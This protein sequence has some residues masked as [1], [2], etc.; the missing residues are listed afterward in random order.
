MLDSLTDLFNSDNFMPHGHC[1]LWEPQILWLHVVSDA[2]IGAAYFSIPLALL[3]F[4]RKRKD[5]PFHHLFILFGLFI[6]LCGTTHLFSIWVLWKPDY[7]PEG[8][9]KALTAL[10]S[11]VTAVITWRIIP[12]ALTLPSP[13]QLEEM[14]FRLKE[15]NL[16]IEQEV[17]MRTAELKQ[18]NTKLQISENKLRHIARQSE[19][20]FRT[21]VDGVTDYALYM[22]DTNGIIIN[23]NAGAQRIKGYE[24]AEIIGQHFSRFYK[25]ED[26]NAGQPAR[27]L[28]TAITEGKYEA[29][30]WR[31]RKDGSSFRAHV[32]IDP[33]YD[34]SHNLVGFAKLTRDITEQHAARTT[35][36]KTR[37]QLYQAQKME[38]IGH[39]T[40]GIAHDFN[41]LLQTVMGG[42][43]LI[44]RSIV[45]EKLRLLI[46]T[47]QKAAARGARLT[48][49]LLAYSRQQ[50]LRPETSDINQ[51]LRSFEI[52]LRQA[53]GFGVQIK[54]D[55]GPNLWLTDIDQ[56]QFQS[57]I[58]NLV[59]NARDAMPAGGILTIQTRNITLNLKQAEELKDIES[60]KYVVVTVSDDGEGMSAE[61]KARAIEPFYTTKEF[62]KGSGLGLSQVY[63]FVRQSG[64]QLEIISA[65][66]EGTIVKLYL[67]QSLNMPLVHAPIL[68]TPEDKKRSS[69]TF[70]VDEEVKTGTVLIVE[71]DPLV[72]LITAEMIKSLGYNTFSAADANEAMAIFAKNKSI[73]ILFTD[74]VMPNGINGLDLAQ[75]VMQTYPHTS[76]LM[77]SGYSK[78]IVAAKESLANATLLK[79]P[80]GA[81]ELAQALSRLIAE[82]RANLN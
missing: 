38:T 10:A 1:F 32:V 34:E 8:I 18:A 57:C 36:E 50:A 43:S 3:F 28:K 60:G 68:P 44:A 45:D 12:I 42:L 31:V 47:A 39:L 52:L 24:A 64:G 59:I 19:Q 65:V 11:A 21:L 79:K 25:E 77:T 53:S 75:K 9:V 70:Y 69:S 63:G 20:Q 82:R 41:N 71:D 56:T 30:T 16:K 72:L 67:P 46:E 5:V 54:F 13:S 35:L 29:E 7:G 78:E 49:Q 66:G 15:T 4:I 62:G 40:G 58:L 51:L 73:D 2:I 81:A 76:I 48:Q 33:I 74:I 26:R 80:Y 37:E 22:L 14:N 27:A 17:A 6:V 61:V 23:W 55:F